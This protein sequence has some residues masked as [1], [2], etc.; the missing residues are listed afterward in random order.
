MNKGKG[1][2]I[3][4]LFKIFSFYKK[5]T[6]KQTTTPGVV[7]QDSKANLSVLKRGLTILK[8]TG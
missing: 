5:Q 7:L 6:K 4:L 8:H 1:N 2:F 3:F